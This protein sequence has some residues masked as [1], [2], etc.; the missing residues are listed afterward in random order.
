MRSAGD[1]A[2]HLRC[3]IFLPISILTQVG[4]YKL[5][6]DLK[7]KAEVQRANNKDDKKEEEARKV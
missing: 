4:A 7:R 1:I 2:S 5:S 6:P 3:N